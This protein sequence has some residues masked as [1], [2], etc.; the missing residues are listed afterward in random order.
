[1]QCV[2]NNYL[3]QAIIDNGSQ[4]FSQSFKLLEQE[5]LEE[6]E[7]LPEIAL[8]EPIAQ[9]RQIL[10]ETILHVALIELHKPFVDN[11][12][13]SLERTLSSICLIVDL[14]I[15]PKIQEWHVLDPIF[16]V[17]FSLFLENK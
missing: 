8:Q 11:H 2:F 13:Q 6:L 14:A 12:P 5:I 17:S 3:K 9:H 7:K 15:D 1:L 16:G 4:E 10:T